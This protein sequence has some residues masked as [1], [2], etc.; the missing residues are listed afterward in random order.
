MGGGEVLKKTFPLDVT[1]N[2]VVEPKFW[3]KYTGHG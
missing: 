3:P 1:Q 2:T